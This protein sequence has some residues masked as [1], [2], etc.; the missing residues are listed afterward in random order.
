MNRIY[1]FRHEAF[2]LLVPSANQYLPIENATKS[3]LPS[4]LPQLDVYLK[5]S[6][7]SIAASLLIPTFKSF[8]VLQPSAPPLPTSYPPLPRRRPDNSSF[9]T[10]HSTPLLLNP[11]RRPPAHQTPSINPPIF[12]FLP[13]PDYSLSLSLPFSSFLTSP[14]PCPTLLHLSPYSTT[15]P[16]FLNPFEY[17][18]AKLAPPRALPSS[19]PR[20]SPRHIRTAPRRPPTSAVPSDPRQVHS[21]NRSTR[22]HRP[23]FLAVRSLFD[24]SDPNPE[25]VPEPISEPISEPTHDPIPTPSPPRLGSRPAVR[26]PDTLP[27]PRKC[28]PANR[29]VIRQLFHEVRHI[30]EKSEAARSAFDTVVHHRPNSPPTVCEPDSLP[31]PSSAPESFASHTLDDNMTKHHYEDSAHHKAQ[32]YDPVEKNSET[33]D[34]TEVVSESDPPIDDGSYAQYHGHAHQSDDDNEHVHH[35]HAHHEDFDTRQKTEYQ[36]ETEGRREFDSNIITDPND[37]NTSRPPSTLMRAVNREST[38]TANSFDQVADEIDEDMEVFRPVEEHDLPNLPEPIPERHQDRLFSEV[39][40]A[41]EAEEEFA[42]AETVIDE[43]D[44]IDEIGSPEVRE[45]IERIEQN[46]HEEHHERHEHH[47]HHEHHDHHEHH[48]YHKHY[49]Q[50][51]EHEDETGAVK[52]DE[53]QADRGVP[54]SSGGDTLPT[55]LG[56]PPSFTIRGE[57][58]S[59][60]VADAMANIW[61][62]F[63]AEDVRAIAKIIRNRFSQLMPYIRRFLAHVVAFWGGITYIRRAIAAFV[64]LLKRDERVRELLERVGWAS[65]TTLK[66]FLS[67]CSMLFQAMLQFYYL[68]RDKVIP[69]A[70]RVIPI[71]YYKSIMSLLTLAKKSPWSLV[72]GPF[73]L[74]F[75]IDSEKVPDRYMLH[76]KLSIEREDVTFASMQDLMQTVRESV[77]RSRY[78]SRSQSGQEPGNGPGAGEEVYESREA[79][80]SAVEYDPHAK[81]ASRHHEESGEES[82]SVLGDETEESTRVYT[83]TT[84]ETP[85]PPPSDYSGLRHVPLSKESG[86][87]KENR[88]SRPLSEKTNQEAWKRMHGHAND[89]DHARGYHSSSVISHGHGPD[90]TGNTITRY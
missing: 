31:E 23:S 53:G 59:R 48:E 72:F 27:D 88:R 87:N 6:S 18:S 63:W 37:G 55:L 14:F 1:G 12:P 60:N 66:V 34:E 46:I 58:L 40:P 82:E 75:A 79:P 45:R 86:R 51:D 80:G 69:D 13:I 4:A 32:H 56:P 89:R 61:D 11:L 81:P 38:T 16:S 33:I 50:H 28:N 42:P 39:D 30:Q 25:P 15:P 67:M 22:S 44:E 68:M 78:P 26:P 74:T 49:E 36:T 43:E 84:D 9:P 57:R 90:R 8:L 76:D 7:S 29:P 70:K 17:L 10:T 52:D 62:R 21:S 19:Q 3:L 54:E 24:D 73:S 20:P 35:E 65:A 41:P 47:E 2:P 71:L 83:Q 77:Y 85:M 64:R 5:R